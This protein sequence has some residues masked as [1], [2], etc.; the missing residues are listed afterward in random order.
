[1]H[2]PRGQYS[3]AGANWV[4][5]RN[6]AAFNIHAVFGKAEFAQACQRDRTKSLVDFNAL[7]VGHRPARPCQRLPHGGHWAQAEQAGFDGTDAVT[8]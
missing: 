3:A 6:G 5:V 8:R 2:Q 7:H 4:T 1:V